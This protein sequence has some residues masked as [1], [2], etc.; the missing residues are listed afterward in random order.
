MLCAGA[1]E[2][3]AG[4]GDGGAD[5]ARVFRQGQVDQGDRAGVARDNHATLG[6]VPPGSQIMAFAFESRFADR[7]KPFVSWRLR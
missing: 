3:D 4:R 1:G 5:P 6:P 2:G 7:A